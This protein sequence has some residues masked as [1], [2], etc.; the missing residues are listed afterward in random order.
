MAAPDRAQDP[1]RQVDHKWIESHVANCVR[2]GVKRAVEAHGV[3][4][5]C[6][7]ALRR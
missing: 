1:A 3:C 6:Q 4:P 7:S 2:C 5:S